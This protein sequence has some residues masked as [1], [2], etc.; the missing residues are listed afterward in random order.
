[1]K[2]VRAMTVSKRRPIKAGIMIDVLIV[3][4]LMAIA[5]IF[6]PS[7]ASAVT[8]PEAKAI[9]KVQDGAMLRAKPTTESTRQAILKYESVVAIRKVVFTD[10]TKTGAAYKWYYVRTGAG[11]GY[12]RSD[13]IK[14]KKYGSAT[15]T[16]TADTEYRKGA[17]SNMK[18]KGTLA[19][20]SIIKV[21]LQ[22]KHVDEKGTWYKFKKGSKYYYVPAA[23]VE[24]TEIVSG[25]PEDFVPNP[26]DIYQSSKARKVI[27]GACSWAKMIAADNR[28]HYG[29]GKAAHHNGCYFCGTNTKKGGRSKKGV[30]DYKFSYCCNPY[31]HAAFAHGGNEKT[32]LEVCQRGSSYWVT[33]YPKSTL[34]ANLGR[35]AM[36]KLRK[37]DV[38][39]S[40]NHVML[41]VGNGQIAEAAGGDDNK[42][43]SEKW[44]NSIRV[45]D[46][47]AG[48]YK[49]YTV[50]RY[51]GNEGL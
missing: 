32:M 33:T 35:P 29:Y 22:G 31:V 42:R 49:K 23:N 11:S 14:I 41:Y 47:G 13:L 25:L 30:K 27:K 48:R 7:K 12:I 16:V 2:R 4:L 10:P 5:V 9:V 37:G 28:F 38:L 15:G 36:D 21:V 19:T 17:G 24:L 26:D 43:N 51:I 45:M 50:Y 46:L 39:C 1:M 20:G 6:M 3:V 34:F 44:N 18:V 8:G 40:S